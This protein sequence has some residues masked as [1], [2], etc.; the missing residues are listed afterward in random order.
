MGVSKTG[1]RPGRQIRQLGG[2]P[3]YPP[4]RRLY[5]M[6]K[7]HL[8]PLVSRSRPGTRPYRGIPGKSGVACWTAGCRN[9]GRSFPAAARPTCDSS[10][11]RGAQRFPFQRRPTSGCTSAPHTRSCR[12]MFAP[13][14]TFLAE[15]TEYQRQRGSLLPRFQGRQPLW[16]PPDHG[17]SRGSPPRPAYVA[18]KESSIFRTPLGPVVAAV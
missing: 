18:N 17:R 10:D 5:G 1:A 14:V 11:R 3:S 4:Q 6:T 9:T 2:C 8:P 13:D 16:L 15:W 12:H 7:R